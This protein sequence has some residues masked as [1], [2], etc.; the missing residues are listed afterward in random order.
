MP[1]IENEKID[2][3][4]FKHQV[5]TIILPNGQIYAVERSKDLKSHFEGFKSLIDELKQIATIRIN[6]EK[7]GNDFQIY[8][9]KRVPL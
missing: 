4:Y 1:K 3:G 8:Y 2:K 5:I 9:L 6:N 7:H